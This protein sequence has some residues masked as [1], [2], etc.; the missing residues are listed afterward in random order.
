MLQK[1]IDCTEIIEILQNKNRTKD[2][3][4][5]ERTYENLMKEWDELK[6]YIKHAIKCVELGLIPR[7]IQTMSIINTSIELLNNVV[8]ESIWADSPE[9]KKIEIIPRPPLQYTNHQS[10]SFDELKEETSE[11]VI[12][13]KYIVTGYRR[14]P[15]RI[16]TI[17]EMM[18]GFRFK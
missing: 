2:Y 14:K 5:S 12:E 9:N 15:F 7:N 4:L 3:E 13:R 1:N 16:P 18:K 6:F 8:G 11:G 10:Y 17:N